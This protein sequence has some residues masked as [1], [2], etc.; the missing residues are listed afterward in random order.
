MLTHW[1]ATPL[2]KLRFEIIVLECLWPVICIR[3]ALHLEYFENLIYFGVANEESFS[4]CHLGED[5]TNAPY[6]DGRGVLLAAEQDLRRPVPQGNHL[7]RIRFDRQ[8]ECPG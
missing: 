4:L 2:W 3:C 6:V 1:N 5:A 8:A 7:V